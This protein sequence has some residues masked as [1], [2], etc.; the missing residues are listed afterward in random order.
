MNQQLYY[1][2][3]GSSVMNDDLHL[4]T[5]SYNTEMCGVK[6]TITIVFLL[7]SSLRIKTLMRDDR[8]VSSIS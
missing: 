3:L 2:I 5:E 1:I 4:G 6:F 8:L 7:S